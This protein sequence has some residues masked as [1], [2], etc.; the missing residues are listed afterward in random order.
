MARGCE[1]CRLSGHCRHPMPSHQARERR[2]A[3]LPRVP[4]QEACLSAAYQ[5]VRLSG[6]VSR[7]SQTF[8][9]WRVSGM[10]PSECLADIALPFARVSA[11]LMSF[12]A[13]LVYCLQQVPLVCL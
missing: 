13:V 12:Q 4:E 5:I 8:P 3:L 6:I 2:R 10:H 1:A 11:A 9:H 7:R